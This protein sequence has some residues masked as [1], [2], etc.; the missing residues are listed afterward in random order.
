MAENGTFHKNVSKLENQILFG[1]EREMANLDNMN[2]YT[3]MPFYVE[4]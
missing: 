4:K 2:D 1:D 3:K